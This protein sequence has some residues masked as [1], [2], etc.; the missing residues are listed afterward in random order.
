[1]TTTIEN[2]RELVPFVIDELK[3]TD[4]DPEDHYDF[5][6]CRYN[7][8][9]YKDNW[10]IDLYYW[11]YVLSGSIENPYE[12]EFKFDSVLIEYNGNEETGMPDYKD[13][14]EPFKKEIADFINNKFHHFFDLD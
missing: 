6:C 8:E 9:F 13:D 1:M 5:Q 3:A 12:L 7:L 10:I 14:I 11:A 4:F 2:L